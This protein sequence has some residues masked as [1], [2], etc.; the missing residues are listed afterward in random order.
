MSSGPQS[1]T[2]PRFPA[3]TKDDPFFQHDADPFADPFFADGTAEAGQKAAAKKR[4]GGKEGG[5][6]GRVGKDGKGPKAPSRD[7]DEL[8]LLAL[9][10]DAILSGR[11]G[12]APP[13]RSGDKEDQAGKRLSR[14]ERIKA[15]KALKRRE[16]EF[17][18]D[19]EGEQGGQQPAKPLDD[20]RFAD[21][22]DSPAFALD[23]T[24]PRYDTRTA[25]LASEITARK[26]K[27]GR[28]R[29]EPTSKPREDVELRM[30]VA[31]VKRKSAAK[32]E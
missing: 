31:A 13:A 17:G 1:V 32:R 19:D 16:R 20:S 10:D 11:G 29:Q 25:A 28:D 12:P 27:R 14:K 23:P 7:A 5:K 21:L 18:S 8:D 4:A 2:I 6:V 22:V 24:D 3:G 26:V 15:K 30:M 9:G